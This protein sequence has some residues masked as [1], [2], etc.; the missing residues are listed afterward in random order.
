ME[1]ARPSVK[2]VGNWEL[3]VVLFVAMDDRDTG[4]RSVM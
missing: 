2:N 4:A 3:A 1:I